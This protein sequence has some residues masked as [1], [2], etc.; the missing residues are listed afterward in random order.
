MRGALGAREVK[1]CRQR[2]VLLMG[3][4]LVRFTQREHAHHYSRESQVLVGSILH[5][6][7]A[8]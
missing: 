2:E 4:S 3:G 1:G 5:D 7:A 6:D 8:S